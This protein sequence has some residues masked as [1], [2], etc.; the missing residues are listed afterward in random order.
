[1]PSELAARGIKCRGVLQR[2]ATAQ[3]PGRQPGLQLFGRAG[4]SLFE[5]YEPNRRIPAAA[6]EKLL[7]TLKRPTMATR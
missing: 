3:I 4:T 7:P 5:A 6:P 1:M 2:A